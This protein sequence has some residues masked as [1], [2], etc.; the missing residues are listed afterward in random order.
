[1]MDTK[2]NDVKKKD[3]K[4]EKKVV[5]PKTLADIQRMKLE[6]LLKNPVS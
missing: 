1:M 6:K 3:K 4:E 5:V 2:V